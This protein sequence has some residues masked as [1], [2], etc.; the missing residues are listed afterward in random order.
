VVANYNPDAS[1]NQSQVYIYNQAGEVLH[2]WGNYPEDNIRPAYRGQGFAVGDVT[3]DGTDEIVVANYNPDASFNQSQVYIYNQA[4]EVLRSWGNYPEDNIRPAYRGQG[5]VVS[6]KQQRNDSTTTDVAISVRASPNPAPVNGQLVYTLKV[7]NNGSSSVRKVHVVGILSPHV[8]YLS[9]TTGC[10]QVTAHTLTCDFDELQAGQ[11][12]EF[13][14]TVLVKP[15]NVENE[16]PVV[17]TSAVS[18]SYQG[19]I[20]RNVRNNSTSVMVDVIHQQFLSFVNTPPPAPDLVGSISLS[21]DK[22]IFEAGEAV[23]ITATITNYGTGSSDPMWVDLFINPDPPPTAANM[24]WNN[25]CDLDPCFGIAW[26]ID[27]ELDPG[28]SIVLTSTLNSFSPEHTIWPGWFAKG[29][30]DLYLYV[31]SYNLASAN[32]SVAESNEAN[33]RA[34]LVLDEEVK[35]INPASIS[36][37]QVTDLPLRLAPGSE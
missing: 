1:F 13:A 18:V 20:D 32:G 24:I 29:T 7:A 37:P 14:I 3:G 9:A 22:R 17:I 10:S 8:T 27:K 28:E 6:S 11:T 31:D 5:F 12:R 25:A 2:S 33:N 36:L 16:G 19:R 15:A 34:R 23:Q 26:Y 35:G 21:P 30:K 4:G